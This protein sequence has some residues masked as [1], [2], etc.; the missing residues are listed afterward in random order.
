MEPQTIPNRMP[1]APFS[2]LNQVLSAYVSGELQLPLSA[3]ELRAIS[4]SKYNIFP[5]KRSLEDLKWFHNGEPTVVFKNIAQA[6][7]TDHDKYR[8]ALKAFVEDF[9][10]EIF[11][12]T[13]E[14]HIDLATA[15]A[16]QIQDFF[17]SYNPKSE[18]KNMAYLFLSFCRESGLIP[19]YENRFHPINGK[20][21]ERSQE[22][23]QLETQS[24]Q[25][26]SRMNEVSPSN[27]HGDTSVQQGAKRRERQRRNLMEL[28]E[29]MPEEGQDP[30]WW[31]DALRSD[32]ELLIKLFP[33]K[34]ASMKT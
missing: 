18:V 5:T 2:S 16:T 14:A 32:V 25:E 8:S 29:D 27:T 13:A 22:I 24:E 15:T 7:Q 21:T 34:D 12:Q 30:E 11:S 31:I 19:P 9:Y 17:I 20:G 1:F 4:I 28:L 3:D 10:L 6:Y 33:R 26:G 23:N